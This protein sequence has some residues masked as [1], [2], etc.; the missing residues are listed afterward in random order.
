MDVCS[1]GYINAKPRKI[2]RAPSGDA[3]GMNFEQHDQE[4]DEPETLVQLIAAHQTRLR[5]FIRC[6]LF[7]LHDVDDVLQETNRILWQKAQDFVP[8]TDFWAW[9]AQVARLEVLAHLKRR[10]RDSHLFDTDLLQ[11]VAA[12]AEDHLRSCDERRAALERCLEQ[13]P[14]ASRQLLELRYTLDFSNQSIAE[15]LDRPVGSIR[16]TLYR[17]RNSLMQ[18]VQRVMASEGVA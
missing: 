15:K 5:G 8:G 2:P 11:E 3:R 12:L 7:D 6:L 17:I 9:S 14:A 18:C 13:Q 4:R 10:R 1:N 16:Q